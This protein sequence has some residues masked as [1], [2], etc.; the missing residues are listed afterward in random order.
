MKKQ[1]LISEIL[2]GRKKQI[3]DEELHTEY[4]SNRKTVARIALERGISPKELYERIEDMYEY[5]AI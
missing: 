2:K 3:T 5:T 1:N 4:F